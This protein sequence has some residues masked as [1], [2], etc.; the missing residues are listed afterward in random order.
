MNDTQNQKDVQDITDKLNALTEE[1]KK[2]GVDMSE[3]NKR[4][5]ETLNSIE[6][7]VDKSVNEVDE[8]TSDLD[9]AEQEASGEIDNLLIKQSE[10]IATQEKESE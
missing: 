2:I 9:K 7:D 4:S 6:A 3:A 1:A 5:E 10:D 8:I